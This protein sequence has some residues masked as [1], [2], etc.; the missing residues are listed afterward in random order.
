MVTFKEISASLD[1]ALQGIQSKKTVLDTANLAASKAS[2]DYM[3]AVNNAQDLR[4]QLYN[5]IEVNLGP[6]NSNVKVF[7]P[8]TA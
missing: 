7:S 3:T 2:D 4:Q 5:S 8:K 6:F 1:L